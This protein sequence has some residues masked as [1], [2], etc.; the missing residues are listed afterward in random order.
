M[1]FAFKVIEH[2]ET[3][4]RASIETR[5]IT[6]YATMPD[7]SVVGRAAAKRPVDLQLPAGEPLTVTLA[8]PL[9][10]RIPK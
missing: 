2:A 9:I 1:A 4:S 6:R 3:R 10:V 8:E 7:P 5:I